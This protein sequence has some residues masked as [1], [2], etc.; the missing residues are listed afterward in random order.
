MP[1]ESLSLNDSTYYISKE[2]LLAINNDVHHNNE[3]VLNSLDGQAKTY[4]SVHS[5]D[6]E[7]RGI[8]FLVQSKSYLICMY[9]LCSSTIEVI[10]AITYIHTP[11]SI[12]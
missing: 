2:M 7:V 3:E 5:I 8:H 10:N 12:G 6:C 1:G 4:L 11:Q 9:I